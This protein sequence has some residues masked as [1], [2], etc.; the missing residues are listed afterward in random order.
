MIIDKSI[1]AVVALILAFALGVFTIPWIIRISYKDR[2]LDLP[3]TR[4]I[5]DIPVPRLG[6]L[7]FLP[8]ITVSAA[9]V[10]YLSILMNEKIVNI[11][12]YQGTMRMLVFI[13]SVAVIYV[14]GLLD[15]IFSVD[16]FIKLIGQLAAS[17]AIVAS[18]VKIVDMGGLLGI[19]YL[20][21]PLSEL[22]SM[23]LLVL[24]MNAIN[25]IDGLDGLS[26]SLCIVSLLVICIVNLVADNAFLATVAAAGIGAV[27]AFWCY[28]MFGNTESRTKLF[29]GDTGG[30]T[31]G[32]LLPFLL[33][34]SSDKIPIGKGVVFRE[35]S[36]LIF[37]TFLVP[38]LDALRV[39]AGRLIRKRSPFL[40]DNT[41][42]HHLLLRCGLSPR[43]VL[44]AIVSADIVLVL[45]AVLMLNVIHW[46]LTAVLLVE[47]ALWAGAQVAV[48]LKAR[49]MPP[50]K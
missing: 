17:V 19:Y 1:F 14:I 44:V 43:R 16:W 23:G 46:P 24:M 45:L 12:D 18:G 39:V 36:M 3:G 11:L 34:L 10:V 48:S 4:K 31:L 32:L 42:I 15:D 20:P 47:V 21:F 38:A 25:F 7:A 29:M 26:S 30:L 8:V 35:S 50:L 27:A 49:K 2:L 9:A 33:M 40:P 13:G 6:G 28:N 41:H 5:H 37:T 22:I